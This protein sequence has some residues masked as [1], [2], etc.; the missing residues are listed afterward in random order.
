MK[1]ATPPAPTSRIILTSMGRKRGAPAISIH[2]PLIV[3]HYGGS[4]SDASGVF[5][6]LGPHLTIEP[7][8]FLAIGVVRAELQFKGSVLASKIVKAPVQQ[9]Q[10]VG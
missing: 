8:Q 3:T 4:Y 2:S 1:N 6:K 5:E 9:P 10:T 7:E